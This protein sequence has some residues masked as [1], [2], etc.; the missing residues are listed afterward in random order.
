[1]SALDLVGSL[2]I[3]A[4]RNSWLYT[5]VKHDKYRRVAQVHVDYNVMG[6]GYRLRVEM[7]KEPSIVLPI[8]DL[9]EAKLCMLLSGPRERIEY[10]PGG[11]S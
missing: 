10:D 9:A 8:D 4:V 5:V 6:L 2:G 11:E 3:A 7:K 1:M